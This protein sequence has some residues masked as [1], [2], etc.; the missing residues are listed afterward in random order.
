MAPHKMVGHSL[1]VHTW[2]CL[3]EA[4]INGEFQDSKLFLS[5]P[6]QTCVSEQLKYKHR[7]EKDSPTS[8]ISFASVMNLIGS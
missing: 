6:S 3:R 1:P 4:T 2:C 8:F 7:K 5:F